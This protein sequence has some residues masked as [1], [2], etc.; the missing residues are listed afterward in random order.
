MGSGSDDYIYLN[1]TASTPRN[2]FYT[3]D[4]SN[5]TEGK[6]NI[7]AFD[8]HDFL[9]SE[10]V[11]SDARFGSCIVADKSGNLF[12]SSPGEAN[13]NGVVRFY[14]KGLNS[15]S[16][17]ETLPLLP[18]HNNRSN[19]G[20]SL[21]I[22]DDWLAVGAPDENNFNG[23]LYLY[24]IDLSSGYLNDSSFVGLTSPVYLTNNDGQIGDLFGWKKLFFR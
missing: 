17:D 16:F 1:P 19:F 11:Y 20:A 9:K 23:K 15:F 8:T 24:T 6:F 14:R 5:S 13:L 18:P 4:Q 21:S 3:N 22:N 12:I 2:L 7:S 10:T